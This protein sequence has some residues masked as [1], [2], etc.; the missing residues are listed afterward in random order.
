MLCIGVALVSARAG[1][2]MDDGKELGGLLLVD[3]AR[4]WGGRR[5]DV[6]RVVG[7]VAGGEYDCDCVGE[8]WM[9]VIGG[10]GLRLRLRGVVEFV[11]PLSII[12]PPDPS[13][14]GGTTAG[15]ITL[16]SP[17]S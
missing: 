17:S 1:A 6:D 3:A 9:A 7:E 14:T 4:S 13:P 2:R 5:G 15:E 12:A 11:I 10:L 16:I 8:P